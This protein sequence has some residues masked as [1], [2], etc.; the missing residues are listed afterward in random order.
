MFAARL[1]TLVTCALIGLS[2]ASSPTK[3]DFIAASFS[4]PQSPAGE[5]LVNGVDGFDLTPSVDLTVTALGWYDHNGDGLIHDHPV[6]I[7]VTSTQTLAAPSAVVTTSS[8]LDPATDFRFTPVTPF[9]LTAGVTYT[10]AGSC[11]CCSCSS[12]AAAVR[13]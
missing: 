2:A 10:L 11:P 12:W 8:M 3:A 13:R 7:F 9:T 4:L 6:G 5:N 1:R